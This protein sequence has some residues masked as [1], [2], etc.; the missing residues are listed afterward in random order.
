MY[1]ILLLPALWLG[2]VLND[3]SRDLVPIPPILSSYNYL[4]F[5]GG[6]T[7]EDAMFH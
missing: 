5:K 7:P 1:N 3:V 2:M 4:A 6:K